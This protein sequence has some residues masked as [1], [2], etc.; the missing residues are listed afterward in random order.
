MTVTLICI[1]FDAISDY[2]GFGG[3]RSGIYTSRYLP[4]YIHIYDPPPIGAIIAFKK[5]PGKIPKS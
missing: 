2:E 1:E 4:L 3:R 5:F